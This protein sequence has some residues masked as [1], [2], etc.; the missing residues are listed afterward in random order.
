MRKAIATAIPLLLISACAAGDVSHETPINSYTVPD[1]LTTTSYLDKNY[2]Q[3]LSYWVEESINRHIEWKSEPSYSEMENIMNESIVEQL[4]EIRDD[5]NNAIEY[6]ENNLK[7]KEAGQL[8]FTYIKTDINGIKSSHER[9]LYCLD[10]ENKEEEIL[11]P[12]IEQ[13]M[14]EAVQKGFREG[15]YKEIPSIFDTMVEVNSPEDKEITELS[16]RLCK[17]YF[18]KNK[19]Q[20]FI[21]DVFPSSIE[22]EKNM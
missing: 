2:A 9:T 21:K 5:Y 14:E 10:I 15:G 7:E 16:R 17:R 18:G 11:H 12:I 13:L 22:V 6:V 19:G 1:S 8:Q 3:G 20:F 4:K